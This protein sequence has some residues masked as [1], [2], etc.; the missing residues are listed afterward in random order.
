MPTSCNL[1]LA[2]VLAMLMVGS[3]S[4]QERLPGNVPPT[5][6]EDSFKATNGHTLRYSL[7]EPKDVP[8]GKTLPLVVNSPPQYP[9]FHQGFGRPLLLTY[10][11]RLP[12]N[13]TP[14]SGCLLAEWMPR[15][16]SAEGK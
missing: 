5:F 8:A 10:Q 6:R 12:R 2:H 7:F 15:G 14:V 9:E 3:T 1:L 4:S 13:S 16:C 11:T